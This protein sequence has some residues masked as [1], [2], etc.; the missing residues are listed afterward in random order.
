MFG[1]NKA[2][3]SLY[4]F[5]RSALA[6]IVDKLK[7]KEGRDAA[8]HALASVINLGEHAIDIVRAVL[9]VAGYKDEHLE[10]ALAGA[11]RYG[12]KIEDALSEPDE[13]ARIGKLLRLE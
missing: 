13:Y 5:F 12:L 1:I 9:N 10:A 7:T 11:Q 4:N 3:K 6:P 2:V 8:T